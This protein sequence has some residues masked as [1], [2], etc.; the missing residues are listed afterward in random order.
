[1]I[2]LAANFDIKEQNP[3]QRDLHPLAAA[4][5]LDDV[6]VVGVDLDL[7]SFNARSC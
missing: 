5:V 7:F 1:V 2:G 6:R 4:V 3:E